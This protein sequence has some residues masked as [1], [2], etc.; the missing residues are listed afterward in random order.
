MS[1]S[2]T[3]ERL[4]RLPADQRRVAL[5]GLGE[6]ELA[7]LEYA[8]PIW[9]RPE[10]LPPPRGIDGNPDWRTWLILTGRGWGKTR[11][12]AEC[13]R[14]RVEQGRA[15]S[16]GL[17]GPTADTLRRDQVRAIVDCS[18]SWNKPTHEASQRRLVWPR[19][20]IAY[21]LSSEEP[22][23]I[24]GLNL[25][26][27][28]GD[29]LTSWANA[30]ECWSNLQLALRVSGPRGDTPHAV[31]STTPKRQRLLREIVNDPGTVVTRGSTFSNAAHL[32]AATLRFLTAKYG[33]TTL[34]RQE[35]EGDLLDDLEGALWHRSMLDE[36]RVGAAPEM[37]RV[38]V[39]IDP[40]G[41]SGAQSDETGIIAVGLARDDHGYVLADAS[42]RHTPEKWARAAVDLL[43]SL[44]GDCLVCERNFGGDMALATIRAVAPRVRVKM[45]TASRGKAVRAEPIVAFYEQRRVHHVGTLPGLEDQLCGWDPSG[46][47][48]SPDR[49]DALV[50]GLTELMGGPQPLSPEELQRIQKRLVGWMDR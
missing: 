48:R 44:R 21:C 20:A 7:A 31:I 35:L 28:W 5:A 2:A 36:N 40:A 22:D 45:V 46:N 41:S 12:S 30:D 8:W 37:K 11:T 9:A 49:L 24:R 3:I 42:G 47:E 1:A 19:G 33:G 38:V 26:L 10:Q 39:A 18:P 34:G 25:D 32:D 4:A 6:E 50:W 23:R 29:E 27:A 13:V 15:V 43:A 14:S 17:I 16:I